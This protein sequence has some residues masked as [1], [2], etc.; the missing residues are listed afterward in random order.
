[1]DFKIQLTGLNEL[2]SII[3]G[4][5]TK[6]SVLLRELGF[7]ENQ[8]EQVRDKHLESVVSRFLEVILAAECPSHTGQRIRWSGAWPG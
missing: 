4:S 3:Y 6:L 5:E 7:E 1:M 8:I 2:L